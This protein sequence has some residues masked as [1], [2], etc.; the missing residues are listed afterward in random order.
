MRYTITLL[1]LF[2][3]F[4]TF[5]QT[6]KSN[7]LEAEA[8]YNNKEYR[9]STNK[10]KEAFI[11]E[12]GNDIDLYNAACSASLSGEKKLAFNWLKL[13]FTKGWS[14]ISHLKSDKDLVPLHKNKKWNKLVNEIQNPMTKE[15]KN[16]TNPYKQN[17]YL[18]IKMINQ[19]GNN[20]FP[21]KKHLVT[22]V[23]RLIA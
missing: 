22:K 6:Y 14:N 9:K 7:I 3:N 20:I 1:C 23:N 17:Y 8:F 16:T 19:S 11:I 12:Q 5:G 13:A 18:F 2:L 21:H 10:Y 15:K 4:L